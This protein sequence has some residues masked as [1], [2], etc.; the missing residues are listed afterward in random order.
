MLAQFQATFACL[1]SSQNFVSFAVILPIQL[2][3][4]LMTLVRKGIISTKQYHVTYLISL[5]LPYLVIFNLTNSD[6]GKSGVF[7]VVVGVILVFLRRNVRLHKYSIWVPLLVYHSSQSFPAATLTLFVSLLVFKRSTVRTRYFLNH[8]NQK[9]NVT[10]VDK[11]SLTHDTYELT[12][13]F[14]QDTQF[15]LRMGEHIT[16]H[17]INPNT[18]GQVWNNHPE[19]ET[20]QII[21]R[22]YTP[23]EI[24]K[25]QFKLAIKEYKSTTDYPNGGKMSQMLGRLSVNESIT[26]SGPNGYNHYLG[27]GR[28][29]VNDKM[30]ESGHVWMICAGTGLTPMY[31]ILTT[32]MDS[33]QDTT[34]VD[35]LYVNKTNRDIMLNHEL[36]LLQKKYSAQFHLSTCLTR[37]A[38]SDADYHGRPD[39]ALLNTLV[40]PDDS[41][42]MLCGP[43][44]FVNV[45]YSNLISIGIDSEYIV[46]F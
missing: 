38:T 39:A 24:T 31:N 35:M 30:I 7:T 10:L 29:L 46:V 44:S 41:I 3:S 8:K 12:F 4:L 37:D 21:K 2:A 17:A 5:L 20:E 23:V 26:I 27:N 40:S 25:G 28:V 42:Y 6:I 34:R 43:K 13:N 33:D 19:L 9:Q 11:K 18:S 1:N 16:I 22:K 45:Y 36:V 14:P 32:I 15:G